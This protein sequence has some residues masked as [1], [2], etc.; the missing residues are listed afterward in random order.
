MFGA[1]P[2]RSLASI[3]GPAVPVARQPVT[4]AGPG[5]RMPGTPGSLGPPSRRIVAPVED[6]DEDEEEAK[7]LDRVPSTPVRREVDPALLAEVSRIRISLYMT[8]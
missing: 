2:R 4:P 6:E 3:G 1:G 5:R 7:P 8:R